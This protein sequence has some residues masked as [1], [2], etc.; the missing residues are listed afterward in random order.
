MSQEQEVLIR[1]S[2]INSVFAKY[3]ELRDVITKLPY[4][5]QNI[6]LGKGLSYLDDGLLWIKEVVMSAPLIL[7]TQAPKEETQDDCVGE[8][9]Q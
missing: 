4:D 1:Q 2:L 9:V 5:P 8:N 3:L 7:G 6:G